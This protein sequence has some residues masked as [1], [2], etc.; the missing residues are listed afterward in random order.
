MTDELIT[1]VVDRAYADTTLGDDAK[2]LIHAALEGD[3]KLAQ[4]LESRQPEQRPVWG[5][6]GETVAPARAYLSAVTVEGFRGIGPATTLQ[7]TP[8]PGL[9]VVSG[10]NGSGKSSF[11]EALEVTLTA[12]SYRW[13]HRISRLHN[14]WRN[15]HD[16]STR[17]SVELAE[18][19]EG[20]TTVEATWPDTADL[21][22]V[23]CWVQ[24]DKQKRVAGLH[25]LGWDQYLW[26]FR[27]FLSHN[28][29]EAL[30]ATSGK[31]HE[32]LDSILGLSRIDDAK[33]RLDKKLKEFGK[34]K[35]TADELRKGLKADL[36]ASEDERAHRAFQELRGHTPD[37][38]LIATLVT[39][40]HT[41]D[42][43]ATALREAAGLELPPIE[44]YQHAVESL[45]GT[46]AGLAAVES[47]I[48]AATRR[49][50]Q[51]LENAL[52]VHAE[53]G[54]GPCPICGDGRLD[55]E[56]ADRSRAEIQDHRRQAE[57]AR[58]AAS[59]HRHA[60]IRLQTLRRPTPTVLKRAIVEKIPGA[61]ETAEAWTAWSTLG[62]DEVLLQGTKPLEDLTALLAGVAAASWELAELRQN[63]WQPLA[64]R[65]GEWLQHAK[66]A[67]E[68][69]EQRRHLIQAHDW[70]KKNA[71][72]LRNARLQPLT[73]RAR[74]VW[75]RLKQES[76]VELG[77]IT[78]TGQKQAR[79]VDMKAAVDGK[80]ARAFE[81]MSQG[82]MNA[83]ALSIFIPKASL[84]D[85]PFGFIVIDDPVQAMDPSKVDGLARVLADVAAERQ[86][87]VFT[88]DDRLPE[89][90]RRLQLDARLVEVTRDARSVVHVNDTLNPAKRWLDDAAAAAHDPQID[91]TLRR[92]VVAEACRMGLESRCRDVFFGERLGKGT[93]RQ[94]VEK[95]W[96]DAKSTKQK[97]ALAVNGDRHA[98]IDAW[99]ASGQERQRRIAVGVC[100]A[101]PH[102]GVRASPIDAVSTVRKL[103]DDLDDARGRT[104]RGH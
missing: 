89:A 29:L 42:G 50:L 61:F 59:A 20:K 27:P 65:L 30:L 12:E 33:D 96:A 69:D 17:I 31:L 58:D 104:R 13:D 7:L 92:R 81:V 64:L 45:R 71:D 47:D 22:D 3:D 34:A 39:G 44:T 4:A 93:P 51:L 77:E 80:D 67:S 55:Q 11:A 94:D 28:E 25:S 21:D 66:R 83:L 48:E 16:G 40:D 26:P 49:R 90:V 60:W 70:L 53:E 46:R 23:Q 8:G 73:D 10:R 101:G 32:T 15:L 100:A 19:G 78:L 72:A 1:T 6:G 86:V 18:E 87:I 14:T 54:D 37:L 24:R 5:S 75:S 102:S 103:V 38:A 62:E 82:E 88:H 57:Q 36:P 76:N 85:S 99:I 56:W 9:V 95:A 2:L 91:D 68:V 79:R 97:L 35:K 98:S 63:A 74:G 41:D 84:P 43:T 52:A